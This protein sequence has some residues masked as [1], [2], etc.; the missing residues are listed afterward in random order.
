MIFAD[1]PI[2]DKSIL[3]RFYNYSDTEKGYGDAGTAGYYNIDM[4]NFTME[5]NTRFDGSKYYRYAL[6][7]EAGEKIFGNYWWI[8]HGYERTT[9]AKR[10]KELKEIEAMFDRVRQVQ[11]I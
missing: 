11:S 10:K 7:T 5:E 8:G 3:V 9:E 1:K 6:N 2:K 4:K